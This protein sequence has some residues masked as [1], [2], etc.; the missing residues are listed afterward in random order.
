MAAPS[1]SI[2]SWR[3]VMGS[4]RGRLTSGLVLLEFVAGMQSL[5]VIAV[6]PRVLQDL[7]GVAFY[8]T[9]FSG[10]MLSGL[11]SIPLAGRA[12]D[13]EGPARPFLRMVAC[14]GL[15]TLLCALAPS[16]PLL[17]LARVVQGY[18]GGAAYTIGYGTVAKSYPAEARPR[19]LALLTA[20]WVVSGLVAPAIGA[21]LATTVGWRWAFATVL[22]LVLAA[23]ALSMPGLMPLRGV[24]DMPRTPVRWPLLVALA[25]AAG[26]FAGSAA[27]WWAIPL[28]AAAV[29]ATVVCVDR[30]LPRG[31][32]RAAPGAPSAVMLA[33]LLNL[34]FFT[35]DSFVTLLLTGVRAVSVA[36]AGVAVTLVAISWS[37]GSW[38]QSRAITVHSAALLVGGGAAVFAGG[39]A[40]FGAL[41]LGAPLWLGYAG[42]TVAGCGVG[43]AFPTILLAS[44]EYA[45]EGDETT[46]VAARFLSGRVGIILGTGLGG[47]AVA[48]AH[49]AGRPL[50]WGLSAVI[51]LAIAAGLGCAL[52]AR[53]LRPPDA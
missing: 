28:G 10:Y 43:V 6:M 26:L 48:A 31:W 39:T 32:L 30:V 2:P 33:L 7:G 11:V 40:V 46:A 15:G 16:M 29:L 9:V 13:R 53:R 4:G 49:A 36:E 41:L 5:V 34:G 3:E 23:G 51:S 20:T 14:F 47:A 37:L 50:S 27:T 1:A 45:R 24:P 19:M 52:A 38:W 44:M 42:W 18:G 22:P 21:V 17:A 8:G 35:A 12:A 25:C